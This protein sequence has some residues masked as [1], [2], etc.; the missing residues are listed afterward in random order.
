MITT[1]IPQRRAV[2]LA[3]ALLLPACGDS[4]PGNNN[5]LPNPPSQAEI[6][7]ARSRLEV[8][9][10]V[11]RLGRDALELL[12]IWPV[13]TCEEPRATFVGEVASQFALDHPCATVSA[14]ALGAEAD[15]VLLSFPQAGCEVEGHTLS[16]DATLLYAG[17]L[18]G[19]ELTA[20]LA[21]L[22]VDGHQLQT[23]LGY[24]QCGDEDAVWVQS[25]GLVPG[26]AD[27]S[28]TLDLTL[29]LQAG[30]PVFGADTLILDGTAT[31]TSGAGT[32]LLTVTA[33]AF[34]VGD[35]LPSSGSLRIVTAGGTTVSAVFSSGFLYGEVEV[36]IDDYDPVRIIIPG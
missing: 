1:T 32:D 19:L 22:A 34:D 15:A 23:E 16:G 10:A 26:H 33:L 3:V 35:T 27:L 2:F 6:D 31:L 30:L 24:R 7:Q 17:S 13:Y 8:A 36:T 18:D 29:R 4:D 25:E 20:D 12:G 9:V 28:F 14:S 11:A 5:H 21:E